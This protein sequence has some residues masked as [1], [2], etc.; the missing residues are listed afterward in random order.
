[1]GVFYFIRG[2]ILW[3]VQ[4]TFGETIKLED[5]KAYREAVKK[6]NSNLQVLVSEMAKV[7]EEFTKNDKFTSA[8][9]SRNKILK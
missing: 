7:T 4:S 8:F 9:T 2:E 5:E 6:I 1:M 3:Q